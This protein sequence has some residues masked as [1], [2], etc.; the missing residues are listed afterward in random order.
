MSH[1]R[2]RLIDFFI[3]NKKKFTVT[4]KAIMDKK[5]DRLQTKKQFKYQA[6]LP[7]V[8]LLAGKDLESESSGSL[9]TID[10]TLLGFH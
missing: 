1:H 2:V 7:L 6:P 10:V 3:T 5:N 9:M 4:F 8:F